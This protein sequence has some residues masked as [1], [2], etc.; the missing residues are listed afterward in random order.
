MP[1]GKTKPSPQPK[2]VAVRT[3]RPSGGSF[4][5]LDIGSQTIKVVEVTGAGSGLRVT[6]FGIDKTPLGT[7]SQGVVS[8][9][10]TLGAAIKA[11]LN[12][13]GV[14]A[15]GKCVSA[16]SG[17]AAVVVRVIEVPKMSMAELAETM[18]WEVERHIPF[19]A[20]DVEMSYQKI[21]DPAVDGDANNPN[22]EVLLACAQRD[23]VFQHLETLKAAGLTAVAIDVEPL[24]VG[25]ALIN[26]SS[27]GLKEK[28]VVVVNLGASMTDVGIF[29]Q[30][31]LRFPRTI[32]LGGDNFTQAIA[33]R[34]GLPMDAAEDEKKQN[35]K[36][37]MDLVNQPADDIFNTGQA[38]DA[39]I[40]SPFDVDMAAPLPPSLYSEPAAGGDAPAGENPFDISYDN[41]FDAPAAPVEPVAAPVAETAPVPEDPKT[42]RQKEVF[43]A[44]NP[45][46]G[47]FVMELQRSIDYFRSRYP[48]ENIDQIILCGGSALIGGLADYVQYQTGLPSVVADPFAGVNVTAR[49]VSLDARAQMAP[50]L[51]V[52]MGLA[53]RDAVLGAGR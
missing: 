17:A 10:K 46:L 30:A 13:A 7:I 44:I 53:T 39:G 49:Q 15:R 36:I 16:A 5:G 47:E 35:G 11:L 43:Y 18:K 8:D 20:T 52:A 37:F 38:V 51:A 1:G 23:M 41:P 42:T 6:A 12:K 26:L 48:T 40:A 3:P 33:D 21:D 22:M 45:V 9:P 27:Q 50:A 14:K 24:A 34:L 2:A 31:V 4:V 29:K 25:R 19:S 28:N 32:P